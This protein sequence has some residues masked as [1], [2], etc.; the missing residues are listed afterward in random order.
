[1]AKLERNGHVLDT[2]KF[3]GGKRH[4]LKLSTGKARRG[5]YTVVVGSTRGST[6]TST[7]TV[8]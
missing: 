8:K 2:A 4:K 5:K 7:F 1:M 3:K 6:V